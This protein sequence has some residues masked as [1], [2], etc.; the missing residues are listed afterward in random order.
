M[1]II[2]VKIGLIS[3]NKD[4]PRVIKNDT[5]KKLVKSIKDF[6][7]MLQIRPIVVDEAMTILGG[8][9]RWKACVEAGMAEVP[10][11]IARGLTPE[12]QREFLIKD[13]ISGGEW[14]WSLIEADWDTDLLQEWGLDI[15]TFDSGEEPLFDEL[16][17]VEKN[18]PPTMKI[19]FKSPEQLEAAEAEIQG[20]LNL[21]YP[22]SYLSVSAGE[23]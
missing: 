5:F 2:T 14:D 6:P 18:K 17:G 10:I 11:I 9:M 3:P 20:L 15:I 8:N 4:N 12:Q 19:T 23:L 13:N 22:G 16:V 21:N 1:E 7:E